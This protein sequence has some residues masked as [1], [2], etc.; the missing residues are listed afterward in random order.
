LEFSLQVGS[1]LHYLHD[2]NVSKFAP[3]QAM[4]AYGGVELLLHV[5]LHLPIDRVNV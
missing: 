1:E 2:K 4:E 5:F 3:L